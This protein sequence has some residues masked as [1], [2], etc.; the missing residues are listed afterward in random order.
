MNTTVLEVATEEKL[1][2]LQNILRF[3]SQRRYWAVKYD[4]R[5]FEMARV[6][7]HVSIELDKYNGDFQG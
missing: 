5:F 1:E 7:A 6:L 2:A 3:Y 4:N